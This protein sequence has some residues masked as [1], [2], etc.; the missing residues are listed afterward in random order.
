MAIQKFP[1]DLLLLLSSYRQITTL[2]RTSQG[3]SF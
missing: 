1:S 2:P 3:Q